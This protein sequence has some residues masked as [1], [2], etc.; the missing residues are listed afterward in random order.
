M[1][2][3]NI[4]SKKRICIHEFSHAFMSVIIKYQPVKCIEIWPEMFSDELSPFQGHVDIPNESYALIKRIKSIMVR[5][6]GYVAEYIILKETTKDINN[7]GD[8]QQVWIDLNDLTSIKILQKLF[9][10]I[11]W[12]I[13]SY[14]IR[15]KHFK[16][17]IYYLTEIMLAKSE[18]DPV[19]H[20]IIMDSN[21]FYAHLNKC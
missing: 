20:K 21:E 9:Y 14:K 13:V 6:S 8:I 7:Q 4:E 19:Y 18:N 5:L 16:I 10:R 11:L 15:S 3:K 12:I 17:M 2:Y 1:Y